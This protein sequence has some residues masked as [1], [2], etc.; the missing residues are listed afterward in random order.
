MSYHGISIKEAMNHINGDVNGWFLP[1]VQ[2]PYVWGSRYEG[3]LYICK[4]FDSILRGYPIGGLIIW[5]TKESIPYREFMRKYVQR[6]YGSNDTQK[7]VDIGLWA[8]K[9]KGLVYDGQQR[10]QT[11]Y[12]CLKYEFNERVLVFD[13]LFD[14]NKPDLDP[15]ETGFSFIEK[16]ASVPVHQIRINS[17]FVTKANEGEERR[18]RKAILEQG[19]FNDQD[20]EIIEVNIRRLWKVFLEKDGNSLAYFP[21]QDVSE[22]EVNDV[23]QRLNTGG[24]PLSQADLLLSMIKS[25]E[26]DFEERL[27][28][29]S[30]DIYNKTGKGYIFD[31]YSILQLIYLLVKQ[32]PRIDARKVNSEEIKEFIM[33]WDNLQDPLKAFFTDFLW[34]QFKV[35]NNSIVPRKLSILPMIVYFYKIYQFKSKYKD[36][37]NVNIQTLKKYFILSQINDWNIQ[38]IVNNVTR[39]VREEA[40]KAKDKYNFPILQVIKWIEDNKWRQTKLYEKTF[41][42]Y[43]W[44][45]LKILTPQRTYQFDPDINGRF[46]PEI[47]HIFPLKLQEQNEEY[48]SSVD[49]LWNMQPIKGEIN[50]FKGRKHPK[51]FFSTD[52]RKYLKNDYDLLPSYDLQESIWDE[53]LRFIAERKK[54]AIDF[55]KTEY[56]LIIEEYKEE[57]VEE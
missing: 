42:D 20:E 52:G 31:A 21:I 37:E 11:L 34:G 57:N 26:Y 38:T 5:N 22:D 47:D 44:F 32:T 25:K 29:V 24:I 12:S 18:L 33:V 45:S 9:D 30:K 3:E 6:D 39:I 1:A 55:V 15:D 7:I 46:S 50:L 17:F 4:L 51:E 48:Y 53:P 49:I 19:E 14:M 54:K 28:E 41:V 36:L 56:D 43:R 35:N 10:L 27:Q 40:E 13:L 8:R 23:F 16:N 2:R